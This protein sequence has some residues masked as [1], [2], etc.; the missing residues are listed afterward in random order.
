[1]AAAAY[2]SAGVGNIVGGEPEALR[3]VA[4]YV[5]ESRRAD[6]ALRPGGKPGAHLGADFSCRISPW[7][8][9]GCV[10]PRRIYAELQK[11][12][13]DAAGLT[14]SPTYFELVWRDF[15]RFITCKYSQSRIG[16]ATGKT[17]RTGAGAAAAHA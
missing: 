14:R 12:V 15:F 1:M 8:A 17:V 16:K 10:S 11:A 13:A 4:A 2:S 3:R 5:A 7:L 6:A 9:L